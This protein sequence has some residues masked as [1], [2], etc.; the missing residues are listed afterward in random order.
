MNVLEEL[1]AW[2]QERPAWLRDA[3]LFVSEVS[4]SIATLE[5]A[6]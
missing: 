2:L 1:L 5:R 4:S 3:P 6:R